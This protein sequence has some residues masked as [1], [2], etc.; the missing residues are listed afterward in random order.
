MSDQF[1]ELAARLRHAV[2]DSGPSLSPE[3]V[4]GAPRRRAPA[5]INH[6]RAARTGGIAVVSLAAISVVVT[7]VTAS[8]LTPTA[9]F[10]TAGPQLGLPAA[11][12][13]GENAALSPVALTSYSAGSGLSNSGGTG[14]V[15]ELRRTGTPE[16]A[17]ARLGAKLSVRG[18]PAR[19]Q[20]AGPDSP[21]W[22]IGAT[23]G[24]GPSLTLV[25]SGLGEW[26]YEAAA[27]VLGNSCVVSGFASGTTS[28]NA[29]S[30]TAANDAPSSSGRTQPTPG[31][32]GCPAGGV[33]EPVAEV[34]ARAV[35]MFAKLGLAVASNDIEVAADEV[36]S[37]ASVSVSVDGIAT[38]LEWS[39]VWTPTGVLTGASGITARPV[40][41]G[42]YRTISPA[43]A[44]DRVN[45]WRWAGLAAPRY[46]TPGLGKGFADGNQSPIGVSPPGS[47]EG[48]ATRETPVPIAPGVPAAPAATAA[49]STVFPN[50]GSSSGSPGAGASP[51]PP[52]TGPPARVTVTLHHAERV[53]LLVGD[54]RGNDWLVPGEAY[55]EEGGAWISV[56]SL[57]DGVFTVPT[58]AEPA[59]SD[60][61]STPAPAQHG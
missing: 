45:D 58:A 8:V 3:L 42:T 33:G 34:R 10:E 5:S 47:V 52:P 35:A 14:H 23:D 49:S 57:V 27:N 7:V 39:L 31:A 9:L 11:A 51:E 20:G 50:A 30:S 18:T 53:L 15:Y 38:A 56:I 1:D 28:S 32:S 12:A 22:V 6:G 25:W 59:R 4:R 44:V 29:S 37:R 55:Q 36:Q 54:S 13:G 43:A 61:A 48:S 24:S 26:W 2:R 19:R 40:D 16:E 60:R 46:T 41:R 17:L 21:S